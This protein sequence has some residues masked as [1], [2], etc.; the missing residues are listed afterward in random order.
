[1]PQRRR[2]AWWGQRS[3]R[4]SCATRL[5]SLLEPEQNQ[6]VWMTNPDDNAAEQVVRFAEAH[7]MKVKGHNLLWHEQY[8]K[9]MLQLNA[10]QIHDA[11]VNHAH[12]VVRHFKGR[13][14][15]WDVVNEV[16]DNDNGNQLRVGDPVKYPL[17]Q[18]LGATDAERRANLYQLIKDVFVAAHQEDPAALLFMNDYSIEA[19][20]P[21]ADAVIALAIKLKADGV[22]I[23]GVGFQC[24]LGLNRAPA[25]ELAANMKRLTDRGFLVNISEIDISECDAPAGQGDAMQAAYWHD[26]AAACV[27]NASCNGITAWGIDDKDSWIKTCKNAPGRLPRPLMFDDSFTAKPSYSATMQALLGK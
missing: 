20:S 11:F 22:P 26:I 6:F 7:G 13:V 4:A 10:Q 24:H 17:Y 18:R 16:I 5:R 21:K 23:D 9:W 2:I 14:I 12:Q 27:A 8:P 3:A 25:T 15:A 1:M 19:A